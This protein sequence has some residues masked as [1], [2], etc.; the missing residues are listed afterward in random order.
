MFKH[1]IRTLSCIAAFAGAA[2]VP[3][4]VSPLT[5]GASTTGWTGG[6][7]TIRVELD[8]HQE[9]ADGPLVQ[10]VENV[11]PGDQVELTSADIIDNPSGW[12]GT[13]L[14]DI[15]PDT[16]TV[17]VSTGQVPIDPEEATPLLTSPVTE[18]QSGYEW[19]DCDFETAKVTVTGGELETFTLVSDDLWRGY[20]EPMGPLASPVAAAPQPDTMNL[21]DASA[22]NGGAYAAWHSDPEGAA[23]HMATPG[24]AVFAYTVATP[25][26]SIPT[27][28]SAPVPPAPAPAAAAPAAAAPAAQPVT[29]RPTYTG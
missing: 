24:G 6:P 19:D 13:L 12:C 16:S 1:R 4:T 14:V 27:E 26:T 18:L 2:L 3:A 22:V 23:Y 28:P 15:D 10:Q 5:A 8:L 7:V 25:A 29:A 21:I 20:V 17:R 9:D 11:T